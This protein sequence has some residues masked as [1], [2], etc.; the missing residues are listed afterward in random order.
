MKLIFK[1]T[2]LVISAIKGTAAISSSHTFALKQGTPILWLIKVDA[3][4]QL[5]L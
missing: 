5:F 2:I 1:A 4:I 3:H